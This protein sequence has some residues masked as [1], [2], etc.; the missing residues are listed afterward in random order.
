MVEIEKNSVSVSSA[1]NVN[2]EVPSSANVSVLPN[3]ETLTIVPNSYR[4]SSGGIFSG[5]KAGLPSWL[6]SAIT[7]RIASGTATLE[8]IVNDLQVAVDSLPTG[9][10]QI[11]T[12]IQNDAVSLNS[13]LDV[14]VSRL[15]NDVAGAI[16]LVETKVTPNEAL[17]ITT[18]FLTTEFNTPN[19]LANSNVLNQITTLANKQG[20]YAEDITALNSAFN[21][22]S[23]G[24]ALNASAIDTLYTSV[25]VD[26]NTGG[27]AQSGHL[28]DLTAEINGTKAKVTTNEA[29][30]AGYFHEWDGVEA[31][32][33]GMIHTTVDGIVYQYYGG[34]WNEGYQ[35]GWKRLDKA[36]NDAAAVLATNLLT[37]TKGLQNQIDGA[38]AT[39]FNDGAPEFVEADGKYISTNTSA[40]LVTNDLVWD[41][42]SG[43]GQMYR[44]DGTGATA[45]DLTAIVFA[46]D[47]NWTAVYKVIADE[48]QWYIDDNVDVS[49]G[50]VW[51]DSNNYIQP[52]LDATKPV[53]NLV[54]ANHIGD[55]YYDKLTGFAYRFSYENLPSD[56]PDRG[57]YYSWILI[58]DVNVTKALADA[59]RAQ[60]TADGKRTVFGGTVAPGLTFTS[61]GSTVQVGTGDLWIPEAGVALPYY[62][63]EIY[64][65]TVV[66][67]T[68]TWNIVENYKRTT[69]A[70]KGTLSTLQTQTDK[71]LNTIV[72]ATAPDT[73]NYTTANNGD[74]WYDSNN[75]VIKKYTYGAT[76]VWSVTTD[77]SKDVFDFADGKRAIYGGATPPTDKYLAT[78]DV[79]IPNGST[80]V[81]DFAGNT[82][83]AN[84]IYRYDTSVT[85]NSGRT[86]WIKATKY[87]DN[88]AT[89][90]LETG[91]NSGAVIVNP[92]SISIGTDALDT[93]LSNER[94][95][96]VNVFS[97]TS[98][99]A[100]SNPVDATVNDIYIRTYTDNTVTPA[101]SVNETYK[102]TGTA[103]T[104]IA[105]SDGL[106]ALRDLADG[107]R[108]IYSSASTPVDTATTT[109]RDRDLWIPESIPTD[110]TYHKGEIYVYSSTSTPKW[111]TATKYTENLNDFIIAVDSVGGANA[112]MYK[113]TTAPTNSTV[114][115][116]GTTGIAAGDL[117]RKTDAYYP[118]PY[119]ITNELYKWDGAIWNKLSMIQAAPYGWA[120][121]ASK[122]I[123]DYTTGAVTGWSM[124]DGSGVESSFKINANKFT[125]VDSSNSH[126]P[127][128]ID[129]TTG[130]SVFNGTVNFTNV[131]G[132]GTLAS[133]DAVADADIT[134]VSGGKILTNSVT[135]DKINTADLVVT[136]G[137]EVTTPSVTISSSAAGTSTAPNIQGGYI[138]GAVLDGAVLKASWLDYINVGVLSDW[139]YFNSSNPIPVGGEASFAKD[140]DGN[141]I[142]DSAGYYRLPANPDIVILAFNN[143]VSVATQYKKV[144]LPTY[145]LP[146]VTYNDYS[147]NSGSRLVKAS[148]NYIT[149]YGAERITYSDIYG[150]TH[151]V[152]P[153]AGF[154]NIFYAEGYHNT[155]CNIT[156]TVGADVAAY[157]GLVDKDNTGTL[158]IKG[159]TYHND[160]NNA[161]NL[162][163]TTGYT[164]TLGT[165]KFNLKRDGGSGRIIVLSIY[166]QTPLSLVGTEKFTI[167]ADMTNDQYNTTSSLNIIMPQM[168]ITV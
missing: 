3:K 108:T 74:Y 50:Y 4:I 24:T 150:S 42:R 26:P 16:S 75:K 32:K 27:L 85:P 105:N 159:T 14:E 99:P 61:G 5:S 40:T 41:V 53:T 136:K 158:T 157:S 30:V 162:D 55:L 66:G 51:Y 132:L 23:T 28:V 165:T 92:K 72:S 123:T 12:S 98:V 15:N 21:N 101:I 163:L 19:V 78:N 106:T 94:N 131:K 139:Q 121:G 134:S 65:A 155:R 44:Y 117:W 145:T 116:D 120:G 97:G 151:V 38:I 69:D 71:K 153:P 152:S 119:D 54:R 128:S 34:T 112:Y 113:Q 167:A 149:T 9:I 45:V 161:G 83:V 25:G 126:T 11:L 156:L 36:A 141:L 35:M 95:S 7:D 90:A 137:I 86:K 96:K 56:T 100:S 168:R 18:D 67:S 58:T 111:Q 148:N 102:H 109:I 81:L 82:I 31:V 142:T 129:A 63:G 138:K 80:T 130:L 33:I 46:T 127:F 22:I 124:A 1:N 20:S 29:A 2:V 144:T 39:W 73:T 43:S 37:T 110:T 59:A 62:E 79:W 114:R 93:Y 76:P 77:I 164:F 70:V 133:K 52:P 68:V 143:S 160:A 104:R 6:D 17:A 60:D 166:S 140:V 146:V 135:A 122:F 91:L 118:A 47:A 64:K 87:T 10:D 125:I 84:E 49:N 107:K 13:K 115:T 88:S 48:A 103:W 57:T 8:S 154:T 89:I 147:I